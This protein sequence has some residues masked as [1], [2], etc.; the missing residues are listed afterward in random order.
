L[1][2]FAGGEWHSISGAF[3]HTHTHSHT[4]PRAL[5][6]L[7][8]SRTVASPYEEDEDRY[9]SDDVFTVY[10]ISRAVAAVAAT[11]VLDGASTH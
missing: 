4:S 5:T 1:R 9:W 8:H 2:L 10:S 7:T 6:P 3:T 11:G